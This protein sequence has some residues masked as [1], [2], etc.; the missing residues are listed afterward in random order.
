MTQLIIDKTELEEALLHAA[1]EV[2]KAKSLR[3]RMAFATGF[4]DVAMRGIEQRAYTGV[5][6]PSPVAGHPPTIVPYTVTELPVHEVVPA[7]PP[8][9][10]YMAH[11]GY[12]SEQ[13]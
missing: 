13:I 11:R 6:I 1:M 8:F 4:T 3:E 7:A 9:D 5:S 12:T 2:D 10:P